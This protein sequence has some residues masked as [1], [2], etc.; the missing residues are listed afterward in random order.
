MTDEELRAA[1]LLVAHEAIQYAKSELDIFEE[2]DGLTKEESE[3]FWD[4]FD[5]PMKVVFDE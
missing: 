1:A 5:L 4:F 2:P 3:K